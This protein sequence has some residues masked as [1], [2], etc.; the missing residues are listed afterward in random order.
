[1]IKDPH[2]LVAR[3]QTVTF[4]DTASTNLN[5]TETSLISI[6]ILVQS[7]PIIARHYFG[8]D[9]NRKELK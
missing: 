2:H 3:V 7:C 8:L 6:N 9:V 1:M 4:S 5:A